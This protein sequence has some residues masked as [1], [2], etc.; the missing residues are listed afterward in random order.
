MAFPFTPMS[1]QKYYR[2]VFDITPIGF[3]SNQVTAVAMFHEYEVLKKTPHGAWI[4]VWG[5]KRFVRDG[6]GKRYAHAS[7]EAALAYAKARKKSAL[8]YAHIRLN[9]AQAELVALTQEITITQPGC[10]AFT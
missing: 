10:F 6:A 1:T 8:K 9:V 3:S 7:K 5:L 4:D 2:V